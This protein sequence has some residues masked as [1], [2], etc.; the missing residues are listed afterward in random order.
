[1]GYWLFDESASLVQDQSGLG[2]HGRISGS[3]PWSSGFIGH[4]FFFNG[5][6]ANKITVPYSTSIDITGQEVTLLAWV[7]VRN[8]PASGVYGEIIKHLQTSTPG[9]YQLELNGTANCT[10]RFN[11]QGK[12]L[13]DGEGQEDHYTSGS[14]TRLLPQVWYHVAGGKTP[15]HIWT[16]LNGSLDLYDDSLGTISKNSQAL[17]LGGQLSPGS[18]GTTFDGWIDE[19]MVYNRALSLAEL[20]EI[21]RDGLRRH[22]L[23]NVPSPPKNLRA[24]Y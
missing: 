6:A 20:G 9:G 11:W 15:T 10:I 17:V 22:A 8:C 13:V 2:N 23:Q 3:V 5:V 14:G 24:R 19:P 18:G 7:K 4:A 1:V 16:A 12:I 21:Y